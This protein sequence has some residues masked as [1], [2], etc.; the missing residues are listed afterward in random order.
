MLERS[1]SIAF[2]VLSVDE[3]KVEELGLFN[4]FGLNMGLAHFSQKLSR[5]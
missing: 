5:I 1:D 2:I 3:V 4:Q